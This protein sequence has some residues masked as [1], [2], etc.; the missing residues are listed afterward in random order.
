[1]HKLVSFW[2]DGIQLQIQLEPKAE[3]FKDDILW[4]ALKNNIA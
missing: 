3:E 4:I 2:Y 1:M